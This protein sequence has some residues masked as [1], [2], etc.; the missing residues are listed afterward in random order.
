MVLVELDEG[1][2]TFSV[3]QFGRETVEVQA[4]EDGAFVDGRYRDKL[5]AATLVELARIVLRRER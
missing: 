5:D 3:R 1:Y 4:N 2:A